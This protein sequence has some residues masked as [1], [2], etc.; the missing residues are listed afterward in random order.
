MPDTHL[1]RIRELLVGHS[2]ITLATA[3]DGRS[4]AATVFYASDADLNLYFVSDLKTRHGREM[5]HDAHVTGAINHDVATWG[6]VI[7]LQIEGRTLV[8][9]GEARL[10]ALDAYLE[11][12]PDVRRL[13]DRPKDDNEKIIAS[14]LQRAPFWQLT[15]SWIRLIDSTKGFGW[16]WETKLPP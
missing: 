2:T 8:L 10:R 11:K 15:P 1:P 4:W 6:E 3:A 14:R 9:E 7:G 16:K 12:F 13:F 5:H